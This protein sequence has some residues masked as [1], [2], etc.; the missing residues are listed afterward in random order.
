[1]KYKLAKLVLFSAATVY[2]AATVAGK[3]DAGEEKND[4]T[5]NADMAYVDSVH[6]WG[7]WGLD[8]EPAAGG[9]TQQTTQALNSRETTLTLRVNSISAL[10][11]QRPVILNQSVPATPVPTITPAPVIP[12]ITTISPNVPIPVGGPNDGF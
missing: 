1:M 8:I 5:Q 10:A 9:L 11:P 3:P 12:G 4:T 2:A 6:Q 7:P